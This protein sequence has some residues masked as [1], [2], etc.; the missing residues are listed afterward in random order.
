MT[1]KA[2]NYLSDSGERC[3]VGK[4]KRL[5]WQK[6]WCPMHYFRWYRSR[7]LGG[8]DKLQRH[9]ALTNDQVN[10]VRTLARKIIKDGYTLHGFVAWAARKYKID[11]SHMNKALYGKTYKDSGVK[12]LSRDEL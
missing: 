1:V 9:R 10:A 11:A 5:S 8:P 4:C 12:G 7:R 2:G 3:K 6:G